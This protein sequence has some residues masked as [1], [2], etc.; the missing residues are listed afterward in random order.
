MPNSPPHSA[1]PL[2]VAKRQIKPR[3][4]RPLRIAPGDLPDD[5]LV[6]GHIC[7]AIT[8]IGDSHKYQL[9]KEKRFPAPLK[10]GPRCARWRM[11]DLRRWLADPLGY[12]AE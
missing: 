1:T 4:R 10:L 12:R 9:V 5:A 3:P 7:N 11:G 8:G 6:V 2:A